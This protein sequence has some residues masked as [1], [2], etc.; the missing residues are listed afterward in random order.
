MRAEWELATRDL[1]TPVASPY[2]VSFFTLPRHWRFMEQVKQ[3]VSRGNVLP[4]GDFEQD[5]SLGAEGWQPQEATLEGDKVDLTAHLVSDEA[6]EGRQCLM[7]QIKAKAAQQVPVALERTYLA[8]NSPVVRL[9]PGRPVRISGWVRLPKAVTASTDGALFYD[10]AG[11]EPLGIRLTGGSEWK[12]YSMYRR[13]PAS[14]TVNVTLALTGLGIVFLD[15]V[16]IEPLMPSAGSAT[17]YPRRAEP[18]QL[19]QIDTYV[20]ARFGQILFDTPTRR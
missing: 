19:E 2:A 8:L 6:K 15:D 1:D 12:H 18:G 3:G 9:Q 7:L 11:G 13:V 20:S 14:G 16:R 4:H 17:T 5:I 10:S